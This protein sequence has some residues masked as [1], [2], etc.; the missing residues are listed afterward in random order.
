MSEIYFTDEHEYIAVEDGIGT[1]G[2]TDYAQEQLGDVVYV[3]LPGVGDTYAQTDEAGVVESVKIASEIYAPVSGEVVEVNEA[4]A[5]NP[6]L[7]NSDPTGDGW[8]FKIQI[9]D[10]DE[11]SGLKDEEEYTDFVEGLAA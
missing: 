5:D 4:L 9:E 11:L 3:E 6:G 8:F 7:V 2:I 10:L 1:V